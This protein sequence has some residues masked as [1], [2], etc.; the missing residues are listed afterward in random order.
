MTTTNSLSTR[1]FATGLVASLAA[2]IYLCFPALEANRAN[3]I[4]T[5]GITESALVLG[6]L[7]L[8]VA[9]FTI[10]FIRFQQIASQPLTALIKQAETN[11]LNSGYSPKSKLMEVNRFRYLLENRALTIEKMESEIEELE[12]SNHE[13]KTKLESAEQQGSL[14]R[15]EIAEKAKL[16][17]EMRFE[18]IRLEEAAKRLEANLEQERKA[19]I[20]AEIEKRTDEIYH[21]M[22]RAVEASAYKALW[23]PQIFQDLNTPASIIHKTLSNLE[24]NW[25][26]SSFVRLK[27]DID[28]LRDQSDQLIELLKQLTGDN[29]KGE[30]D[31][32]EG[33]GVLAE[34]PKPESP[35]DESQGEDAINN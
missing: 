14:D 32:E 21:Q 15:T 7:I 3:L 2:I 10:L 4:S 17:K 13:F 1:Y 16:I 24:Q 31:S 30:G 26:S 6:V 34:F 9:I 18:Q 5:L 22:E 12:E 23:F 35:E 29:P 11:R 27:S 33:P 8:I 19:D 28:T 20:G 25:E